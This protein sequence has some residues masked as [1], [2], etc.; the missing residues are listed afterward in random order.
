[1]EISAGTFWDIPE[2][3]KQL[4]EDHAMKTMTDAGFA[5]GG[6]VLEGA[7]LALFVET[8]AG[9]DFDKNVS[10]KD[11]VRKDFN[12]G[13]YRRWAA[14]HQDSLPKVEGVQLTVDYIMGVD[15][16]ELTKAKK[17][18]EKS[19]VQKYRKIIGDFASDS[20]RNVCNSYAKLPKVK[21]RRPREANQKTKLERV[22]E[23]LD[24]VQKILE[25][26]NGD[27][28]PHE[29]LAAFLTFRKKSK[30]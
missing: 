2:N 24:D 17:D 26:T 5:A 16:R 3:I 30:I 10:K 12:S 21:A 4:N 7:N 22:T 28:I 15:L 20:W 27:E 9:V 6:R 18:D 14:D 11:Q 29:V 1:M 8:L 25:D 19:V 23:K 13:A